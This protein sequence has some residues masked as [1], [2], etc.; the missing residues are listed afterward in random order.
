[1]T[2]TGVGAFSSRVIEIEAVNSVSFSYTIAGGL[3]DGERVEAQLVMRYA[4]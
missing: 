1:M 2:S 4:S 3:A